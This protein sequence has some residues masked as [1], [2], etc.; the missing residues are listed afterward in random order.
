MN[1]LLFGLAVLLLAAAPAQLIVGSVRDQNGVPV[2]RAQVRLLSG[3]TARTAADGTFVLPG[4]GSEVEISCDYCVPAHVAVASDGTVVAVVRRYDAVR[5]TG[6]SASD[7]ANLPYAR[8]ESL[9]SLAPFVVLETSRNPFVGASL[10][11]RSIS[12]PGGLLVVDGVPDYDSASDAGT[13]GTLPYASTASVTM[14]SATQ[15][16]TYGDVA[17]AGTFAIDTFGGAPA[18]GTGEQ[19]LVDY[20]SEPLAAGYSSDGSDRRARAGAQVPFA[21][22]D[23]SGQLTLASGSQSD[24]LDPYDERDAFSSLRAAYERT[25]GADV[26][27]ELT[28]DRGT[29]DY[30]APSYASND[31]WS[32]VSERAGIRSHAIVAPFLEADARQTNAWYWAT[33]DSPIAGTIR[34]SRVYGGVNVTLPWLTAQVAYG[35]NDIHYASEYAGGVADAN[36]HDASAALDLHPL[37]HWNL[38]TSANSGYVVQPLENY[39]AV[40]ASP[41]D[42]VSTNEAELT[43]S[44][45]DRL[46]FGATTL[47]TRSA[48]GVHDTSAGLDAAWQIAPAVSLRTWW[49]QVHP[50]TGSEQNVGS[51]WLTATSGVVRLD[52]IWRRD[53]LDLTGNAHLDGAI[54][55][56]LGPHLRVMIVHECYARSCGSGVRVRL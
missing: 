54:S 31:G 41:L 8:A 27:A 29:S 33:A 7:L 45:L 55:T 48:S 17:N 56:P 36:G 18:L 21:L 42:L 53:L 23:A 49:L 25:Q 24:G 32:D 50:I 46:R 28:A 39:E 13:W 19:S 12:T 20:S 15:G 6:P 1:R 37:A 2:V 30:A 38:E 11:D 3:A 35:S 22:P 26:F 40:T 9:A 16:G 44:D 52:L 43:Y 10:H 5:L 34:Q 4:S 47:Q 51:A 14:L